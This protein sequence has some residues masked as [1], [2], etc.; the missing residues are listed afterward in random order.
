MRSVKLIRA[1]PNDSFN[2]SGIGSDS[3]TATGRGG[4]LPEGAE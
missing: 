4:S 1:T 3:P 2:R